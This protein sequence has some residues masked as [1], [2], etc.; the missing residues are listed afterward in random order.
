MKFS[1]L[2]EFV[3]HCNDVDSTQYAYDFAQVDPLLQPTLLDNY[4]EILLTRDTLLL[5][6]RLDEDTV[7]N[8]LAFLTALTEESARDLSRVTPSRVPSRHSVDRLAPGG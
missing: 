6:I 5:P 7:D 8:L 4:E 3:E 1:T 2:R